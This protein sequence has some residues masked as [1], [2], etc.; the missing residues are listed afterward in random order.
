MSQ[1]EDVHARIRDYIAVVPGITKVHYPAPNSITAN[2]TAIVYAGDFDVTH[3]MGSEQYLA[4]ISRVVLYIQPT[5]TPSAIA[6]S[7]GLSLASVDQ[8][9]ANTPG[10]NLDG[11]VDFC[12]VSRFELSRA[13]EVDNQKYWGSTFYIRLKIRRFA[14]GAIP[15]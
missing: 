2:N 12:Q 9:A 5:D 4:G 13:Y 10:F 7:D 8:F 11:L 14:N 6:H 15:A 1:I 3:G